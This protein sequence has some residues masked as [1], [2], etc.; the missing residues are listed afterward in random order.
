MP[1]HQT[2]LFYTA[3]AIVV[4]ILAFPRVALRKHPRL[5]GKQIAARHPHLRGIVYKYTLPFFLL[6]VPLLFL[7]VAIGAPYHK[8]FFN[9]YFLFFPVLLFLSLYD[10]L[11]ALLTGVFP[12]TSRWNLDQFVLEKGEKYR[13]LARL[14]IALALLAMLGCAA[15]F[16][17]YP[18]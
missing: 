18:G 4:A 3:F 1:L 15:M 11:F 16:W 9:E 8:P 14:Q 5:T 13:R 17:Y 12:A 10:G 2:I 7:F 6:P